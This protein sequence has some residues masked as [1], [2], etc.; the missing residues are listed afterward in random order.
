MDKKIENIL[1]LY[2][3]ILLNKSIF[4]SEADIKGIDELVYNPATKEG[5]SIGYGYDNGQRKPGIV[6]DNHN[7]HLHIGFTER[8]TAI[9]VID[10][11]DSMGLVTTENPYAKKDPNKKVDNVHTSGS[12]HYK[13]FPGNPVVGMAVDISGNPKKITELIQWINTNYAGEVSQSDTILST[14]SIIPSVSARDEDPVLY[15]MIKNVGQAIFSN[16]VNE[17]IS[18]GKGVQNN[19]GTVL[20]P[21]DSNNRIKSPV[22][23]IIDNSNYSSSCK[24]QITVKTKRKYLQFCGIS[25]PYVKDGET[26]SSGQVLGRTNTDVEVVLFDSSFKRENINIGKTKIDNQDNNDKEYSKYGKNDS[27]QRYDDPVLASLV[28]SPFK[29]FQN[30]YD[31]SGKMIEKRLGYSTDKK[32]VDPWIINKFKDPF[33][34]KKMD[35]TIER[36]KKLL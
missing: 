9:E 35:E 10:K 8:Q 2:E 36:I 27:T 11:A 20:I 1:S 31:N 16:K 6:W 18:F 13:N 30:Q 15:D 26:V 32:D 14:D 25:N 12:L 22:S 24:N 3:N 17:S 7:N 19:N 28:K 33:K 4:I 23:G 29:P 5:G 34:K 21:K